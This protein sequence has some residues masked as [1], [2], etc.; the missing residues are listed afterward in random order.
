MA[1]QWVYFDSLNDSNLIG[2]CGQ[3]LIDEIGKELTCKSTRFELGP[4][5]AGRG[6]PPKWVADFR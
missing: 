4:L 1:I 2:D 3:M 6:S 5:G